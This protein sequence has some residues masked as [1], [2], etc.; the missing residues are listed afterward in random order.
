MRAPSGHCSRGRRLIGEYAIRSGSTL[1][2]VTL[3][4]RYA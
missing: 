4:L 2:S 1:P 3:E